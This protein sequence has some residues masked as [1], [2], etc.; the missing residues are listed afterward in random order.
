MEIEKD[1]RLEL[2]L[3]RMT[4]VE[5]LEFSDTFSAYRKQV[6]S[7]LSSKELYVYEEELIKEFDLPIETII[8]EY[9]DI[10]PHSKGKT[11]FNLAFNYYVEPD[12]I[13]YDSFFAYK[14][15][16]LDL[17]WIDR[18]LDYHLECYYSGDINAFSRFLKIILRKY[19]PSL[20]P[21]SVQTVLEWVEL[22][23][24]NHD[25][26]KVSASS[27]E[28]RYKGRPKREAQDK[29]TCLNQEQTVLLIYY[30][31]KEKALFR[32]EYLSDL[33]A[34][35]AFEIL[36]G[37]SQH[38]LRQNLGKYHLYQNKANLKEL[39]DL[40]TRLKIALGKDLK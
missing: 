26:G 12:D 18:F 20:L 19:S 33:D 37:Y 9:P 32:D 36:T 5:R 14:I 3:N 40:L 28:K 2:N 38:T 16:Q 21:E 24:K 25:S 22:K 39:D 1:P 11:Y 13:Y 17:L 29:L 15:R 4:L 6:L 30:L 35:R 23:E 34:G 27:N 7:L 10:V 31:Q 8:N